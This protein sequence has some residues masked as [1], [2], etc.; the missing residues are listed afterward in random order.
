MASDVDHGLEL[1]KVTNTGVAL[2]AD[3]NPGLHGS[4]NGPTEFVEF[5][6]NLYFNA[7]T[8]AKGQELWK[9]AANGTIS[10]VMDINPGPGHSHPFAT[11][12]LSSPALPSMRS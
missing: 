5:N 12:A 9:I 1:W 3:I 8:D 11:S 6:G 2:A 4:F 7:I 10:Q